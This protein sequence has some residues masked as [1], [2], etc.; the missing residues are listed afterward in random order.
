MFVRVNTVTGA[1]N[2]DAGVEIL[3]DKV[4]PEVSGQKGF[5]GLTASGN[6]STGDFGIL[7]LWETLEDLKA[8]ESAVSKLRQETIKAVGGEISVAIMEQVIGEVARAQNMVGCPLRIV[9]V[10]MD[11]AKVDENVEF[12]RSEVLPE[13][14]A[15]PGFL[16]VRNLVDRST[17]D[18]VVGTTW[19]D[20]DSLRSAEVAAEARRQ[21][22]TDRGVQISDPIYRTVLFS[23]LV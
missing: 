18:A 16:A 6:R 14:K 21:R 2:M 8:S 20:E 23:H 15:A 9:R 7:G 17:G 3:R 10:K 4:L 12:F 5:R 22:A 1:K 19:A 11:P 13:I